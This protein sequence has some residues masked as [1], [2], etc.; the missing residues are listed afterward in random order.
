MHNPL[1]LKRGICVSVAM[2]SYLVHMVLFIVSHA[3]LLF[4]AEINDTKLFG[5]QNLK[6]FI[7]GSHHMLHKSGLGGG[8]SD[9]GRE[10][11]LAVRVKYAFSRN[12]HKRN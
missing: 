12:S 3:I 9:Q 6:E 11:S 4:N 1:L 8:S 7:E 5:N 2:L 10:L